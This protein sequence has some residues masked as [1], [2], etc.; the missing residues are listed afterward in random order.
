MQKVTKL[1]I[2]PSLRLFSIQLIASIFRLLFI[3]YKL[4]VAVWFFAK[5]R[6]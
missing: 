1:Y 4:S 3:A 2:K 6:F 5:N